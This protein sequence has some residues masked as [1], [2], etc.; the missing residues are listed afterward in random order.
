M[1]LLCNQHGAT[2]SKI[3]ETLSMCVYSISCLEDSS[4]SDWLYQ[5]P[6]IWKISS[7]RR[8]ISIRILKNIL[9]TTT[10]KFKK[11][12][13]VPLKPQFKRWSDTRQQNCN[14]CKC[15]DWS[16]VSVLPDIGLFPLHIVVFLLPGK[17]KYAS[18]SSFNLFAFPL[19]WSLE[20]C[21][22]LRFIVVGS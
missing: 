9:D 19:C 8:V 4:S 11:Q 16:R 5:I 15:G 6:E 22:F 21:P 17:Y 12:F 13:Q 10:V 20:R 1:I 7:L 14:K 3:T 2:T 18:S